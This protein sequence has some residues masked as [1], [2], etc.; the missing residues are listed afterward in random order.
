MS[1]AVQH[2][3]DP[4]SAKA[5]LLA[6]A[7]DMECFSLHTMML[8]IAIRGVV[9]CM[10][11]IGEVRLHDKVIIRKPRRRAI[12]SLRAPQ[13]HSVGGT[14]AERRSLH[15]YSN[16]LFYVQNRIVLCPKSFRS[17]LC[18][19][20]LY[21]APSLLTGSRGSFLFISHLRRLLV[22]VSLV[23]ACNTLI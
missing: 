4:K 5:S 11:I 3:P 19:S 10:L 23:I 15:S 21:N 8:F 6:T 9:H 13:P 14:D 22:L 7:H 12:I 17:D 18:S 1:R 2:S 20:K 16:R